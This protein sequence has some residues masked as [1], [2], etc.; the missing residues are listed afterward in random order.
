MSCCVGLYTN[1]ATVT[2]ASA[3]RN[4]AT[5]IAFVKPC[6]FSYVFLEDIR[7]LAQESEEYDVNVDEVKG[8]YNDDRLQDH[9]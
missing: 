9:G 6:E 8:H 2:I 5:K 1:G 3:P 4:I 7:I